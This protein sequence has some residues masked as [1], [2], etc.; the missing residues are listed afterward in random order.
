MIVIHFDERFLKTVS[1][2][3]V[4]FPHK[5]RCFHLLLHAV[6]YFDDVNVN[7][8]LTQFYTFYKVI[9]AVKACHDRFDLRRTCIVY[10]KSSAFSGVK[11]HSLSLYLCIPVAG[12]DAIADWYLIMI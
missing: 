11:F 4:Y 6:L 12:F 8:P 2:K 9:G 1:I 7:V 5:I 10:T 3:S